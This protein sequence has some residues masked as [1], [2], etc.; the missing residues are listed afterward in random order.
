M[1]QPMQE[2]LIQNPQKDPKQ[3]YETH[4]SFLDTVEIRLLH[5]VKYKSEKFLGDG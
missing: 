2:L 1:L 3:Y 4:T 5:E